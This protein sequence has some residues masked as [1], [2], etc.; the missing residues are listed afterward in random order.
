[1]INFLVGLLL[2]TVII[3]LVAF[4]IFECLLKKD[5]NEF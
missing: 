4:L 2:T 1:M 5:I 3:D